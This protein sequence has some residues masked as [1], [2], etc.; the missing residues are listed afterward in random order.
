MQ[1]ETLRRWQLAERRA[2]EAALELQRALDAQREPPHDRLFEALR[3]RR[4]EAM[5]ALQQLMIEQQQ[6]NAA[7]TARL[8]K[9]KV[10]RRA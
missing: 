9:T 6:V 3:L 1:S 10:R 5:E 2:R 4:Q 8:A 7:F